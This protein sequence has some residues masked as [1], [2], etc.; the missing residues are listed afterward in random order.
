M[1][2]TLP[3]LLTLGP[4]H[5]PYSVQHCASQKSVPARIQVGSIATGSVSSEAK[6]SIPGTSNKLGDSVIEWVRDFSP[7]ASCAVEDRETKFG[8]K[9]A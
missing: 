3:K 6:A 2:L 1:L 9:V 4:F 7:W 8:T 5:C